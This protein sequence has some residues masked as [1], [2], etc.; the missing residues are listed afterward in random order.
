VRGLS[1]SEV[2][3]ASVKLKKYK[4]PGSGQ[5]PAELIET[6]GEILTEIHKLINSIWKSIVVPVYRKGDKSDYIIIK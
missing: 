6:G 3:I 1:L 5:I 2:E 4:L